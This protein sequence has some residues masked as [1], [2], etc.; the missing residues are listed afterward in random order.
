M[1]MLELEKERER[2]KLSDTKLNHLGK[3]ALVGLLT[4]GLAL[5]VLAVSTWRTQIEAETQKN[6]ANISEIKS[7]INYSKVLLAEG[8]T[9]DSLIELL[10]AGTKLKQ[11]NNTKLNTEARA[12]SHTE[13][14][15]IE[16]LRKVLSKVKERNRL[17]GHLS[18]I[19]NVS[20]SADG[21]NI[22]SGSTDGTIMFWTLQ[23]KKL[24]TIRG[25]GSRLVSVNF[26]PDGNAI[27]SVTQDRIVK[28]WSR[29]GKL[30]QPIEAP[31]STNTNNSIIKIGDQKDPRA[32]RILDN[33]GTE[34]IRNIEGRLLKIKNTKRNT[35]VGIVE[36]IWYF[37][38]VIG[39]CLVRWR[40]FTGKT[41]VINSKRSIKFAMDEKRSRSISVEYYH[42]EF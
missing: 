10:R 1:L 27:T 16:A 17:K 22:T 21:K 14:Q 2:R 40:I 4:A 35:V 36:T 18:S 9:F 19:G 42:L 30:V 39:S 11:V 41:Q 6:K 28:F 24:Q 12:K 32:I 34:E 20:F 25:N 31:S 33:K 38:W 26:N 3:Q 13:G 5:S 8:K 15:L 37:G 23:G 7:L 29:E